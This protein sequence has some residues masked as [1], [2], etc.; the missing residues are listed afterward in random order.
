MKDFPQNKWY[1]FYCL[2]LKEPFAIKVGVLGIEFIG[3][4]A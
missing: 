3:E 2:V 4:K 1:L